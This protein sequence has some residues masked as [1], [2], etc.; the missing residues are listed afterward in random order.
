[1]QEN[2]PFLQYSPLYLYLSPL[3]EKENPGLNGPHVD[4]L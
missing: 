2:F 4:F 3:Y 1:M